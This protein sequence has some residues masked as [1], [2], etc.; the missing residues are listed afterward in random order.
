MTVIQLH[1]IQISISENF[2]E[3]KIPELAKFRFHLK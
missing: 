1:K 2:M 3:L